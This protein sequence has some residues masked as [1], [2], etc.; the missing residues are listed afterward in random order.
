MRLYLTAFFAILLLASSAHAQAVLNLNGS[1][2][3]GDELTLIEF[4][5]STYE[6]GT[7]KQGEVVKG[8]FKFK[9][10]GNGDLLI[11]NVKPSCVCTTLEYPEEAL[12]PG[13]TGE[14]YAEIDTSD[15]EGEQ[16]KY[17]TVIYN[18]NPPIERVKLTFTVE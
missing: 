15:K 1:E 4:E 13:E 12:K 18:G 17:F 5:Q 16:V 8:T 11:E 14:I 10:I 3:S 6:M 2:P 7:I 9:N